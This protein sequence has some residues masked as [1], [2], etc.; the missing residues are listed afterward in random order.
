MCH[1]HRHHILYNEKRNMHICIC[2]LIRTYRETEVCI[3]K[4]GSVCSLRIR[5][6]SVLCGAIGLS[7]YRTR[8]LVVVHGSGTRRDWGRVGLS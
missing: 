4:I 6:L 5:R 8:A 1:I 3:Y 2:A 7:Q